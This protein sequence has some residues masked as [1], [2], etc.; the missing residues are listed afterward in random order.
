MFQELDERSL[1]P[2]WAEEPYRFLLFC[3]TFL[4]IGQIRSTVE[5]D[6]FFSPTL[7]SSL[8]FSHWPLRIGLM[9]LRSFSYH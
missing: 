3:I 4:L 6:F 2:I 8:L 9:V 7:T 5:K 1:Y